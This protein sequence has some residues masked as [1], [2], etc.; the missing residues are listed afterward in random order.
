ML[1]RSH[2]LLLSVVYDS[3]QLGGL[4]AEIRVSSQLND[5]D[6]TLVAASPPRKPYN[7]P[8]CRLLGCQQPTKGRCGVLLLSRVVAVTSYA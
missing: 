1:L 5:P 2:S 7:I 4:A 3:S 8:V 6:L